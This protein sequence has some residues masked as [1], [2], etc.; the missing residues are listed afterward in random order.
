MNG[1]LITSAPMIDAVTTIPVNETGIY[2]VTIIYANGE[3][4]AKK[5][6]LAK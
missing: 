6:M 4:V 1:Q 5:V 3:V 2:L